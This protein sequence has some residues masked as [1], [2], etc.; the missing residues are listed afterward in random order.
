M[1]SSFI[2]YYKKPTQI[3]KGMEFVDKK[4]G[5][6]IPLD[7]IIDVPDSFIKKYDIIAVMFFISFK[8]ISVSIIALIPNIIAAIIVLGVMGWL[9]IPLDFMT[10][11]IA[12]IVIGIGVDDTIHYTHRFMEEYEYDHNY[13]EAVKRTHFSIG[14]AL[15]YTTITIAFGF[16]IL[17][18]SKFT[19][20]IYFG[21][22]TSLSML[23]A[24]FLDITL[25]PAL[26]KYYRR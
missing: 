11:T 22:L 2:N 12:A 26:L 19:P 8:R 21:F 3:Y 23:C 6:T 13:Y 24:L 17:I 9:N 18:L 4:L 20:I 5:G 1:G 14:R 10:I 16:A 25:L 15:T 7:I